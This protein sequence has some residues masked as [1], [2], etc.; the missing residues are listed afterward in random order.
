MYGVGFESPSSSKSADPIQKCH[1]FKSKSVDLVNNPT[2]FFLLWTDLNQPCTHISGP[3]HW[4][5][6]DLPKVT[7]SSIALGFCV[8]VSR[9]VVVGAWT[10]SFLRK[11]YF[12][13]WFLVINDD[14]IKS[15]FCSFI[16]AFYYAKCVITIYTIIQCTSRSNGS[17]AINRDLYF[18]KT[19][20]KLQQNYWFSIRFRF[21]TPSVKLFAFLGNTERWRGGGW[22]KLLRWIF[23]DFASGEAFFCFFYESV[24]FVNVDSW[25]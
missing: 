19:K 21:L 8:M 5:G 18:N 10:R 2:I 11:K 15:L 23:L 12:P 24:F 7:T 13:P 4:L 9:R 6:E 14:E 22:T 3:V 16:T 1:L 25:N 17:I 20:V